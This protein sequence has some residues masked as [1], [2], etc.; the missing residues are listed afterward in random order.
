MRTVLHRIA[1]GALAYIVSYVLIGLVT[2]PRLGQYLAHDSGNAVL[3]VYHSA[4][5]P[6]WQAIGWFTL[7]ANGVS[8]SVGQNTTNFVAD[9]AWIGVIHGWIGLVPMVA[10]LLVGVTVAVRSPPP[11]PVPLSVGAY[12]TPGYLFAVL[13]S[14]V[15]FTGSGGP[16]DA[17]AMSR[18]TYLDGQWL[19]YVLFTPLVFGSLGA[20]LGQSPVLTATIERFRAGLSLR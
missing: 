4:G 1:A 11:S 9:G 16:V 6:L 14:T 13:A 5:S 17:T 19:V 10:C 7:N 12:M 20:L 3:D 18:A 8:I 2:V 15:V